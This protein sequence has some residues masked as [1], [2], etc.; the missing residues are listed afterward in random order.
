MTW[1]AKT[2]FKNMGIQIAKATAKFMGRNWTTCCFVNK[3][4]GSKDLINF[5]VLP[6]LIFEIK[7]ITEI[8]KYSLVKKRKSSRAF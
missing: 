1:N 7:V 8:L 6:A 4:R 2:K 5:V 3:F